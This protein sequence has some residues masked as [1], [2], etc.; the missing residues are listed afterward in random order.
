MCKS[1]VFFIVLF[2]KKRSRKKEK[3]EITCTV[4][5]KK[6]GAET[7]LAQAKHKG[8]PSKVKKASVPKG[9]GCKTV[10]Q[11][12]SERPANSFRPIEFSL[13]R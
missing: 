3:P 4:S 9:Y 6:E 7:Q 11:E 2:P 13:L 12:L 10:L 5:S 1:A 8:V